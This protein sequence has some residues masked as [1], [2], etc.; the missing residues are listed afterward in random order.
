MVDLEENS[1]NIKKS[2]T[3]NHSTQLQKVVHVEQSIAP[4]ESESV[5]ENP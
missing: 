1:V 5:L 3:L 2:N 4:F